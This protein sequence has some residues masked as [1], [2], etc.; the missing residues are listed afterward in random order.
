MNT[1]HDALGLVGVLIILISYI[2]LQTGHFHPFQLRYSILNLVGSLGILISLIFGDW[3]LS[4]ALIEIFWCLI[5]IYGVVKRVYQR[6]YALIPVSM[7][8]IKISTFQE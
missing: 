1:I 3:N 5:S 6:G 4:A 8:K 7:T 2:L